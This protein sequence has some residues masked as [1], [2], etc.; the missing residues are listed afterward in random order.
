MLESLSAMFE[1]Y[2]LENLLFFIVALFVFIKLFGETIDYF[3][4]KFK[5]RYHVQSYSDER[6]EE[7]SNSIDDIS[8]HL[9]D[10]EKAFNE[11]NSRIDGIDLDGRFDQM[12]MDIEAKISDIE[13]KLSQDIYD[14]SHMIKMLR[15]QIQQSAKAYILERHAHFV[16][17]LKL[18]DE[19]SLQTLEVRF[20]YYKSQGGNSYIDLMMED[21]RMLPRVNA[22]N[23]V[24]SDQSPEEGVV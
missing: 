8:R 5:R 15:E 18:I 10:I 21:L 1:N 2:S 14:N 9:E 20:A 7:L 16:N 12:A 22:E 4:E 23:A 6:H 19:Q 17:H 11:V 24:I 3:I 13:K